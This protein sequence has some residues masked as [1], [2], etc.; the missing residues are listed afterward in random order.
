MA[1]FPPQSILPDG[2]APSTDAAAVWM[3]AWRALHQRADAV[4][5]H[6]RI[7]AEPALDTTALIALIEQ[8]SPWQRNLVVQGVEDTA[9]MLDSGLLAL[10]TLSDRGQDPAAP[11]LTL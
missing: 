11:A 3:E 5:R 9:E 7:G 1:T 4:A 6:A 10:A 2:D 8:A